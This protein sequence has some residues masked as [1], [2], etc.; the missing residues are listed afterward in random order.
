MWSYVGEVLRL[1]LLAPEIVEA[2]VE[3]R[4]GEGMILAPLMERVPLEWQEQR[5][6]LAM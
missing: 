2:V 1:T 5:S 3:G 4:Q 6:R